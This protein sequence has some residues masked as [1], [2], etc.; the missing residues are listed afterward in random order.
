M[1]I[2]TCVRPYFYLP[3]YYFA[4][5]FYSHSDNQR[6]I[7]VIFWLPCEAHIWLYTNGRDDDND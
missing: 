7:I 1:C 3:E 6:D 2:T 4:T 5:G